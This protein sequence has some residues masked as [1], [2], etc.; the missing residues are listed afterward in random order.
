MVCPTINTIKCQPF[1]TFTS[2]SSPLTLPA[3]KPE[4]LPLGSVSAG[5]TKGGSITVLLT[6]CLTGL[7]SAL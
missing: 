4:R 3:S 6:F 5:N 1:K 2:S 7:E